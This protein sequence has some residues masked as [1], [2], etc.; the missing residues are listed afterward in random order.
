MKPATRT[1]PTYWYKCD[2]CDSLHLVLED[3]DGEPFG[4]AVLSE[5]QLVDMLATIR[6]SATQ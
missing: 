3:E 4:S 2:H 6:G 1:K 5:E